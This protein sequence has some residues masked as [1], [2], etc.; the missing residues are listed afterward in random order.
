MEGGVSPDPEAW[1]VELWFK[2][3]FKFQVAKPGERAFEENADIP[4][5]LT[6]L[7]HPTQV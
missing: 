5:A 3:H 7:S 6:T 2:A 4:S 1:R